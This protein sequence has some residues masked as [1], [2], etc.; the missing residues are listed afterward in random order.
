[1]ELERERIFIKRCQRPRYSVLGAS[2]RTLRLPA[3]RPKSEQGMD[4]DETKRTGIESV[5]LL[6]Q[7][8]RANENFL[9]DKCVR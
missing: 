1:M 5:I 9:G 6:Y 8:I 4:V 3:Q 7:V 2:P